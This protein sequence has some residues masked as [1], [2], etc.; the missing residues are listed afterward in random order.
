MGPNVLLSTLFS[1]TLN[2]Y[3]FLAIRDQIPHAHQN[4]GGTHKTINKFDV[5]PMYL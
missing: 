2:L 1:N 5:H 3:S 4:P